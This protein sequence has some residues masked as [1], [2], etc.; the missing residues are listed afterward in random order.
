MFRRG[1]AAVAFPG[2][3]IHAHRCD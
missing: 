2:P 1:P 3:R